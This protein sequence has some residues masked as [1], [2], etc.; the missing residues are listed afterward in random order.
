MERIVNIS[1]TY[2]NFCCNSQVHMIVR[3]SRIGS[4]SANKGKERNDY[5]I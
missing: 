1:F 3:T 5:K 2:Q 4:C